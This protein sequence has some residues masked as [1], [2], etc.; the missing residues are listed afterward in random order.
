MVGVDGAISVRICGKTISIG[1]D[2]AVTREL[3]ELPGVEPQGRSL[4]SIHAR[5]RRGVVTEGANE[6]GGVTVG[7]LGRVERLGVVQ[8]V[9]KE[10]RRF[11][12][13]GG[14][15]DLDVGRTADDAGVSRGARV[16]RIF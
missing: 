6:S 4:D 2:E 3:F 14:R 11:L 12:V 8:L 16:G 13:V 7:K 9:T 1:D 5:G 15:R 10:S